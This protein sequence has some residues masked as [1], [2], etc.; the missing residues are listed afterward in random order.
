MKQKILK[1]WN[2]F[3]NPETFR[4]ACFGVLTMAIGIVTYQGLLYLGMDYKIAN[5]ISLI[6]GKL[7]AYVCNK[8]FVF[9]VHQDSFLEWVK[10]F[11]R[12]VAAR[13]ATFLID[14]FGVILFVEVFHADKVLSKYFFVILV[15]VLNYI[16]GKSV[17]FRKTER[18]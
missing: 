3:V 13:G 15:L 1:L 4:Y 10:E 16:F 5:L 11:G 9:R 8:W 6:V 14:Y 2:S 7:S 18:R 17:V 12:F